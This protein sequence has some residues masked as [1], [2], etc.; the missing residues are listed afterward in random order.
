MAFIGAS[1]QSEQGTPSAGA[2]KCRYPLGMAEQRAS[3]EDVL[4]ECG[5][6]E[7]ALAPRSREALERDGYALFPGLVDAAWLARLRDAFEAALVRDGVEQ[8]GTRHAD[9]LF[10]ADA[11]FDGVYTHPVVLAAVHAV[12]ACPFRVFLF[13]GRD[14]SPGAGLQGLHTDWMPRQPSEPFRVVTAL[15]YLDACTEANGA[16]RVVPG[17]H[18]DPRPLPRSMQTPQARHPG[19]RVVVAEA[20]S[21]L[22]FNGHL[23]HG[24]TRNATDRPRRALQVQ[25]VASA[26][27]APHQA[28]FEI[29]P[30]LG[31]AARA[32]LGG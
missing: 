8:R 25:Y 27:I 7:G 26:V 20:G 30:R 31:P 24:G 6:E 19:E 16:T 21:V 14:P 3:M 23:W 15:W 11:S 1:Q 4:R 2:G 32:L 28:Q 17:S 29:P 13:N 9:D 22:V 18:V 10:R 12:L 5:V